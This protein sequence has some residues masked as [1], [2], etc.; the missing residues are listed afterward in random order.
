MSKTIILLLLL[1]AILG[2]THEQ[3]I[4]TR[5]NRNP[6]LLFEKITDAFLYSTYAE[7]WTMIDL[8]RLEELRQSLLQSHQ[9]ASKMALQQGR[10]LLPSIFPSSETRDWLVPNTRQISEDTLAQY[11]NQTQQFR[12][13]LVENVIST[14]LRQLLSKPLTQVPTQER[15]KILARYRTLIKRLSN[16]L[17]YT[18]YNQVNSGLFRKG[19]LESFQQKLSKNHKFVFGPLENEQGV[20]NC[21]DLHHVTILQNSNSLIISIK[22]PLI[23]RTKFSIYKLHAITT[24]TT[25]ERT[26]ATT[27]NLDNDYYGQDPLGEKTFFLNKT[28]YSNHDECND[29]FY[30]KNTFVFNPPTCESMLFWKSDDSLC[31]IHEIVNDEPQIL[32]TR[33]GLIYSTAHPITMREHCKKYQGNLELSG[34]GYLKIGPECNLVY[35]GK[36]Y[37]GTNFSRKDFRI[38]N[39]D[40]RV[41]NLDVLTTPKTNVTQHK[42]TMIQQN[43]IVYANIGFYLLLVSAFLTIS[44]LIVGIK[45]YKAQKSIDDELE[46]EMLTLVA[47]EASAE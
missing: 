24:F 2:E 37:Q 16:I 11:Q 40:L 46:Q 33:H 20:L 34:I 22:V 45:H 13:F 30:F 17:E 21:P 5:I 44:N 18:K 9:E 4:H 23:D 35:H 29:K 28:Q 36:I 41:K 32:R 43:N 19:A 26:V 47:V 27:L 14:E 25:S 6:G 15:S 8:N 31:K 7:V 10:E 1:D 12:F 38:P 39:I 3:I 42:S